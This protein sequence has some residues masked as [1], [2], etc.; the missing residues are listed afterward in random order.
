MVASLVASFAPAAP[1]IPIC[2]KASVNLC[3]L[4]S[5]GYD[6]K[7]VNK[8]WQADIQFFRDKCKTPLVQDENDDPIIPIKKRE[9][10]EEM[11]GNK[12]N[13]IPIVQTGEGINKVENLAIDVNIY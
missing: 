10:E 6:L 13:N 11:A 3:A 5:G 7:K 1:G 8:E 9:I 2:T 4:A 12:M